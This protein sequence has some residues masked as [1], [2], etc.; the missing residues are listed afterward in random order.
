MHKAL[1][2]YMF[3]HNLVAT[4]KM[5]LIFNYSKTANCPT[6]ARTIKNT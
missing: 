5:F 3:M 4:F 1:H 6:H 2:F